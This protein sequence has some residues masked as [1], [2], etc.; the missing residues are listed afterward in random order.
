RVRRSSIRS[1]TSLGYLGR[2]TGFSAAASLS[3]SRRWIAACESL[4]SNLNTASSRIQEDRT[5]GIAF[6]SGF[7]RTWRNP[8]E[9]RPKPDHFTRCTIV[10]GTGRRCAP[11][12]KELLGGPRSRNGMRADVFT[13]FGHEHG[14]TI[15]LSLSDFPRF[16]R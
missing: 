16:P 4:R 15:A 2:P 5:Q 3:F 13:C 9:V 11:H 14:P 1:A 6:R 12:A 10:Y 7:A 8:L